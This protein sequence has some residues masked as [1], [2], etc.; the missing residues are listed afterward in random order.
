LDRRDERTVESL[1]QGV[2]GSFLCETPLRKLSDRRVAG[3]MM[4]QPERPEADA[5]NCTGWEFK[6]TGCVVVQLEGGQ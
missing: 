3:R 4:T 5:V 6:T 2:V 1:C